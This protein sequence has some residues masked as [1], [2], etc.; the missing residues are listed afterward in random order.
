MNKLTIMAE[1]MLEAFVTEEKV[2]AGGWTCW[3]ES[4]YSPCRTRQVCRRC[5]RGNCYYRY[6]SWQTFC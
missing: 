5:R 1:K 4:S 3:A 2:A 6:G